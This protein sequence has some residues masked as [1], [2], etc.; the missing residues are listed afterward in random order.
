[1]GGREETRV[2][3]KLLSENRL[4]HLSRINSVPDTASQLSLPEVDWIMNLTWSLNL[5][6]DDCWMSSY[7]DSFPAAR[8]NWRITMLDLRVW[9]CDGS[10]TTNY[11][12]LSL[13]VI[14]NPKPYILLIFPKVGCIHIWLDHMMWQ[15]QKQS[16]TT[17][18]FASISRIKH[19]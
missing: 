16:A 3:K 13:F 7:P 9:V 11:L 4:S 15:S 2:V 8:D 10:N 18:H 14:V 17:V 12:I 1:M 5:K 6:S 19:Y